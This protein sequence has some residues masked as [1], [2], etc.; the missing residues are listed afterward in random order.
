[1]PSPPKRDARSRAPPCPLHRSETG[2]DL[3]PRPCVNSDRTQPQATHVHMVRLNWQGYNIF[4]IKSTP[5]VLRSK[6]KY[7]QSLNIPTQV[8][9]GLGAPPPLSLFARTPPLL[10][11]CIPNRSPF[12]A[13]RL[14]LELPGGVAVGVLGLLDASLRGHGGPADGLPLALRGGAGVPRGASNC[15][16]PCYCCCCCWCHMYLCCCCC[17]CLVCFKNCSDLGPGFN[18]KRRFFAWPQRGACRYNSSQKRVGC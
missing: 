15:I 12:A 6:R 2:S 13:G 14:L 10:R 9:L 1:M 3:W 18:G 4:L 5:H 8:L 17:C 11:T 16:D 7:N